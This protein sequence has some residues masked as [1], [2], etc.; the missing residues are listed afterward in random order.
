M[1]TNRKEFELTDAQHDELMAA[2]KPTPV[3]FLPGGRPMFPSP[4]ENANRAWKALGSEL[5]FHAMTVRPVAGK[6]SKFFT[7]DV[8]ET[9][10]P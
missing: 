8:V 1:P 2:C 5:G 9:A 10:E 4:Q 6:S 3:M 7:A